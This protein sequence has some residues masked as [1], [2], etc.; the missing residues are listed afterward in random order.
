MQTHPYLWTLRR[1]YPN[2]PSWEEKSNPTQYNSDL[3]KST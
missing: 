2:R 1:I 3:E